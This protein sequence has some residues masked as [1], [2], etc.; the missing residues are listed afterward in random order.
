MM[1]RNVSLPSPAMKLTGFTDTGLLYQSLESHIN[2]VD[3]TTLT[4]SFLQHNSTDMKPGIISRHQ[5]SATK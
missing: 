1:Q 5:L 3:V 4:T 2:I